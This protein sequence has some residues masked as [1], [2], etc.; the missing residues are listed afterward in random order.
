MAEVKSDERHC[1]SSPTLEEAGVDE[2][3]NG[4]VDETVVNNP[5]TFDFAKRSWKTDFTLIVEG[6]KFHVAK[7]ILALVSPVFER[8]FESDFKES[9]TDELELPGK[10]PDDVKAFLLAIYPNTPSTISKENAF[11]ILPLADEYH[12]LNLTRRCE[13]ALLGS[14]DEM[15][16][17]EEL[18]RLIK[19][20]HLYNLKELL[21]RCVSFISNK[22]TEDIEKANRDVDLPVEPLR[23]I[24]QIIMSRVKELESLNLN[25]AEQLQTFKTW[26][27]YFSKDVTKSAFPKLDE[28]LAWLGQTWMFS[29]DVL[30]KNTVKDIVI[31]W[32]TELTIIF[33]YMSV[34]S[35][36]YV[37]RARLVNQ[38]KREIQCKFAI[39][40]AILNKMLNDEHLSV[41][42]T[43]KF[44]SGQQ[45]TSC[46]VATLS[47]IE[48]PRKGFV[49]EGKV[50]IE[51]NV[52]MSEPKKL[53][54]NNEVLRT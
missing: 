35:Y 43:F 47:D 49:Y 11:K 52:F 50:Q 18:Y 10:N 19:E 24:F 21:K 33:E 12:V 40:F 6:T 15:T 29:L 27:N 46:N 30:K 20:A 53:E 16:E 4:K 2:R 8:M 13:E 22:S 36:G 1:N 31:I 32:N 54:T 41:K 26:R 23:S 5:S 51:V 45:S 14:V 9:T 7:N 44:T 28:D 48:D 34:F 17:A 25:Q 3:A 39:Q 38:D 42:Q 37:I